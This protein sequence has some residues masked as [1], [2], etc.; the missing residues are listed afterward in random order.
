[1]VRSADID[2]RLRRLE[3]LALLAFVERRG[4][5]GIGVDSVA[6]RRRVAVDAANIARELRESPTERRAA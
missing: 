1:M 5:L 2:A 3:R 4:E 6:L